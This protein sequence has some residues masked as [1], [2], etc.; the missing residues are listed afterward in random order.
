V[1]SPT[2]IFIICFVLDQYLGPA[3]G[4]PC[5]YTNDSYQT[6]L[7]PSPNAQWEMIF[8]IAKLMPLMALLETDISN[9]KDAS[10]SHFICRAQMTSTAATMIKAK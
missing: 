1:Y 4:P 6:N 8:V 3:S 7:K 2:E 9:L 5:T 10:C